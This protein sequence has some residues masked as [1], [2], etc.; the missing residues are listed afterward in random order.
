M[1]K[2]LQRIGIALGFLLAL[3]PARTEA[4]EGKVVR[5]LDGD[6]IEV[7]HEKHAKRVRLNGIDCPSRANCVSARPWKWMSAVKIDMAEQS[8]K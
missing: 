4:F 1:T 7:M 2:Q 6:T 3:A 8:E 5:V